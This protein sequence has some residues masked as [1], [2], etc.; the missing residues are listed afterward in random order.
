M[1]HFSYPAEMALDL[2]TLNSSWLDTNHDPLRGLALLV[3][4]AYMALN[5][6]RHN[7]IN[8][9]NQAY[10]CIVQYCKLGCGGHLACIRYMDT[11]W[12]RPMT[13]IC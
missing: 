8:D 13:H 11:C 12:S 4:G 9:S 5:A 7:G 10:H 6:I 2:W 3:Y 1:F